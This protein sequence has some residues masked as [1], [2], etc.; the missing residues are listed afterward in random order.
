[1]GR[2]LS[3]MTASALTE[4]AVAPA[5]GAQVLTLS[6]HATHPLQSALSHGMP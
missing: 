1:M 2:L 5:S 6:M 4:S 3:S